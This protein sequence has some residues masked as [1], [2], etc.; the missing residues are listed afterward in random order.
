MSVTLTAY[1]PANERAHRPASLVARYSRWG[2]QRRMPEL[3]DPEPKS[4]LDRAGWVAF[5]QMAPLPLLLID[6]AEIVLA[7]SAHAI[8]M[9]GPSGADTGVRLEL[10]QLHEAIGRHLHG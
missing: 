9:L 8:A 10:G 2:L 5:V 3:V 7:A 6:D 4:E 1:R